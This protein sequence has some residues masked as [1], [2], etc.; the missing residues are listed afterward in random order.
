MT[1]TAYSFGAAITASDTVNH[2]NGEAQAIYV[3]GA[4]NISLVAPN[5]AAVLITAPAVGSTLNIRNIR[6]NATGT[7]ATALVAL[8]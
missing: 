4:G 2:A 3:G 8:Y 7:T 1:P 5:G 6:V